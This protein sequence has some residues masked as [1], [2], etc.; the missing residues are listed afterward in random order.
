[1]QISFSYIAAE[2]ISLYLINIF[3]TDN[4]NRS[5]E[6]ELAQEPAEVDITLEPCPICTRTFAPQTLKKHIVICE[7]AAIKRRKTFDSSRQRR[8]GT[9][10]A[11]FLPKNFGLPPSKQESK[12]SPADRTQR[13]VKSTLHFKHF[14]L[15]LSY[16]SCHISLN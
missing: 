12:Q 5:N 15:K 10:L 7:R 11:D 3:L 13:Q 16:L 14:I 8:E 1:M 4:S 9:D 6:P 2:N